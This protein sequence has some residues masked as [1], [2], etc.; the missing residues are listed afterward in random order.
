ML[1]LFIDLSAFNFNDTLAVVLLT[2]AAVGGTKLLY[3]IFATKIVSLLKESDKYEDLSKK[4]V[5]ALL[6]GVG[7]YLI[8]KN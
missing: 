8:V 2:I 6:I 4:V 3:A 7:G 1:P 5:G